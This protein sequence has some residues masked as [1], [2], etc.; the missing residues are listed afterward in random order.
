MTTYLVECPSCSTRIPVDS[1]T[2]R[3]VEKPAPLLQPPSYYFPCCEDPTPH[4]GLPAV[5]HL[6][7]PDPA[8]DADWTEPEPA[9]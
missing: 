6:G 3:V 1:D 4:L 8:G 9:A 5:T 2:M 7:R